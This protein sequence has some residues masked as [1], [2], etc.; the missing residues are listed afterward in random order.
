[1]ANSRPIQRFRPQHRRRIRILGREQIHIRRARPARDHR[2]QRLDPEP[3]QSEP[4][5]PRRRPIHPLRIVHGHHGDVVRVAGITQ[6]GITQP[7]Q[8]TTTNLQ[9]RAQRIDGLAQ[10]QLS[11]GIGDVL[12]ELIAPQPHHLGVRRVVVDEHGQQCRLPDPRRTLYDHQLSP[13]RT[14]LAQS[15]PERVQLLVPTGQDCRARPRSTHLAYNVKHVR[16]TS[17]IRVDRNAT[18]A[19]LNKGP[20]WAPRGAMASRTGCA[21]DAVRPGWR[22]RASRRPRRGG[23]R[24]LSR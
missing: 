19:D 5:R 1:M 14:S 4:Q 21:G 20:P 17:A 18:G 13:S 2:Q 22:C 11:R 8:Q 16:S 3:T 12:F 6:P 15:F 23:T 24:R 7:G 9:L 10:Q